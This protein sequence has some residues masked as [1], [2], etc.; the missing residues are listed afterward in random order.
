MAAHSKNLVILLFV[1]LTQYRSVPDKQT[2]GGTNATKM[3]KTRL[4]Q[5]AGARKNHCVKRLS[6]LSMSTYSLTYY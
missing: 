1:V 4:A 3:A 6:L 5:R 2:D